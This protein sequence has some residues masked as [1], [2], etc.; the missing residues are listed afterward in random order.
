MS[1]PQAFINQILSLVDFLNLWG[2]PLIFA[3]TFHE[4]AQ[5]I[6][7]YWC[8]DPTARS[9]GRLS[10]NPMSHIDWLGNCNCTDNFGVIWHSNFR[11]G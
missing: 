11:M 10:I 1:A 6:V 4:L 2:L 9:Q 3:I 5:G 8:S 7:A